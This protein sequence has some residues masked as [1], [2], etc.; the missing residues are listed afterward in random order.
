MKDKKLIKVELT[1]DDKEVKTLKGQE[2]HEWLEWVNGSLILAQM[3]GCGDKQFNWKVG[4]A[5]KN[6]RKPTKK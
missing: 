3:H 1:Y 4:K 5:K 2:A 6:K